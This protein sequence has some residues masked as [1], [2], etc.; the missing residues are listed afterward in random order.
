MFNLQRREEILN[1]LNEHTSATVEKLAKMLFVSPPTLRRDLNA[2]AEEGKVLR[3]HGGVVLRKTA[4]C[5][6]PLVLREEENSAPKRVIAEKAARHINNGDVIFLD[7][8]STASYLIPHFK[9]FKDI[10]VITNSP[11]SSLALGEENIKNYCTGGLLLSRSVAYVGSGA[12]DFLSRIN[13]DVFFFSSRGYSPGGFI[14]DSS[15]EESEIKRAMMKNAEKSVYL[16]DTSKEGKKYMYNICR[17]K[18]VFALI[19]EK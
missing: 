1:Y 11:K 18:D 19:N 17:T 15:V 3:T 10:V 6:I 13:A 4:E 7:A 2:L 5:E 14:T 12:L 16:C 8:S 9:R